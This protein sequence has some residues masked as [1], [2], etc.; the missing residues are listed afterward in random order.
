MSMVFDIL[1][2]ERRRLLELI[3]HYEEQLLLL[4]KGAASRKKR[5][6]REYL[7]RAYRASDKVK[8]EYVG[9]CRSE[10]AE[11]VEA[12]IHRR[13]EIECKRSLAKVNLAEVERGLRGRRQ[14]SIG[15]KTW[16]FVRL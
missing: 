5:G 8:F 4:P 7:Y 2:Q 6:N 13:Q 10:A 1:E 12:R 3:E 14:L 16:L 9:P 11:E 15:S